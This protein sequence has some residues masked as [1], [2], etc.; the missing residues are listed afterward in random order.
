M[1]RQQKRGVKAWLVT[2]EWSGDHAK[3]PDKV[4]A[5]FNARWSAQRVRKFVEFIY[6]SEYPLSERLTYSVHKNQNPYLA[7]FVPTT[8]EIHCGHNPWLHARCV[9]DLMVERDASG[10]ETAWWNERPKPD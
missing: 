4:A 3:R 9:D 1:R 8:G 7:T 2:W 5:I 10:K 6:L